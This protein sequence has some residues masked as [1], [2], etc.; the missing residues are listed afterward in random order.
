MNQPGMMSI[1]LPRVVDPSSPTFKYVMDFA[2]DM[3]AKLAKNRHKGDREGWIHDTPGS[4]LERL[5]EEVKELELAIEV[6]HMGGIIAEAADVGNFAMMIADIARTLQS[7][8]GPGEFA[9]NKANPEILARK[10]EIE[11]L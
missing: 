5:K 8:K 3:E 7:V 4:L 1:I 6:A 10:S 11:P 9:E 2:C